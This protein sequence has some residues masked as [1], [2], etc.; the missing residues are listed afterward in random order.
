MKKKLFIFVLIIVVIASVILLV[1]AC[2]RPK[3]QAA[4][5]ASETSINLDYKRTNLE[6]VLDDPG[7]ESWGFA[8]KKNGICF[9]GNDFSLKFY[10]FQTKSSSTIMAGQTDA[11]SIKITSTDESCLFQVMKARTN[12]LYIYTDKLSTL[13]METISPVKANLSFYT[14]ESSDSTLILDS[15]GNK[16]SVDETSLPLL[17][18]IAPVSQNNSFAIANYDRELQSGSLFYKQS[19]GIKTLLE[20]FGAVDLVANHQTALLSHDTGETIDATLIS[21]E[22]EEIA[23]INNIDPSFAKSTSDGYFYAIKPGGK[24]SETNEANSVFF[25]SN[26]GQTS[27]YLSSTDQAANRFD[28]N[29]LDYKNG[30]LYL[31]ETDTIYQLKI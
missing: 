20:I 10:S 9:A 7:I 2:S 18:K 23:G 29:G 19:D 16:I 4:P 21:D 28:I 26:S 8:T 14:I 12:L 6:K 11:D 24:D 13:D 1:Y 17:F 30:S 5:T 27:R 31:Q 25:I 22:G 15:L 3:E